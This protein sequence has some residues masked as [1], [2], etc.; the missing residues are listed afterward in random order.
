[1]KLFKS[2]NPMMSEKT[3]DSNVESHSGEAMTVNGA[4]NKT[5]VFLAILMISAVIGWDLMLKGS[6]SM[7]WMYVC[8]FSAIGLAVFTA[9]KPQFAMY[10]GSIYCVLKGI[11]LGAISVA[12]EIVFP[13]I[14][15]QAILL[16]AG[17]AFGMLFM[18]KARI[19]RVTETFRSVIMIA[20]AGIGI[21]YLISFGLSF[22]GI[23]IPML[24]DNGALGIGF[25]V[26]VV[27][28]ASLNLLLDFDFIEKGAEHKAPKFM[29]WM[30]AFGL[31]VTLVWL[32]IEILR[33]LS[34]LND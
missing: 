25:S 10:T 30:G 29:E 34:K 18:F 23:Q 1:M 14:V 13:G 20:T 5:L 17:T 24:H 16:T 19:I 15:L 2:S 33:L 26:V 6:M 32:Y 8:L 27:A 12:Y 4:A 7:T 3:F 9:F 28:L 22:A 21:F 11:A 31:V